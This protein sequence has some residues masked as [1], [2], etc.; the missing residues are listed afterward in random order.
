MLGISYTKICRNGSLL[1]LSVGTVAVHHK[2]A[3]EMCVKSSMRFIILYS[4]FH[5][6]VANVSVKTFTVCIIKLSNLQIT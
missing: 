2:D 3:L 5:S 4:L 1:A 6:V